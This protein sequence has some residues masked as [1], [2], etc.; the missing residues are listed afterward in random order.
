MASL[1]R[2][3][4]LWSCV[5]PALAACDP[6]LSD[7]WWD[8]WRASGDAG[9]IRQVALTNRDRCAYIALIRRIRS[10]S[11]SFRVLDIGAVGYPWSIH[12]GL[13]DVIFDFQATH[14]PNCFSRDDM[15]GAQNC[16]SS[17]GD[18]CFDHLFTRERCCRGEQP[19]F[20]GL[21]DGD[22]TNTEGAGWASLFRLVQMTG[23][24]DLVITSH[25]LED[26]TDPTALVRQLPKVAHA[27]LVVVPCK[28]NELVR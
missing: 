26:L 25:L 20:L 14:S 4:L 12:A 5:P 22:V 13:T 19:I 8:A 28:F 15:I 3:I 11:P 7:S 18:A 24:F 23:K 10:E 27:G 16:C 1:A 2:L 9:G 17:K 6:S 21:I